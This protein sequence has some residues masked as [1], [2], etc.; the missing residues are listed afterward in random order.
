MRDSPKSSKNWVNKVQCTQ[1]EAQCCPQ[2][3]KEQNRAANVS[4]N[5]DSR[6][7]SGSNAW[8]LAT[9]GKQQVS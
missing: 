5:S 9:G 6:N 1:V 7:F 2:P 8:L 3:N 4:L